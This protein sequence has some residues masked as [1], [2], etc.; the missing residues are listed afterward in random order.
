MIPPVLNEA[1]KSERHVW[2]D[3]LDGIDL[4]RSNDEIEEQ[5]QLELATKTVLYSF[6]HLQF[7]YTSHSTAAR[8][9]LLFWKNT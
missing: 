7:D 5:L 1:R 3:Q 2:T 9:L 4:P 6:E 8:H